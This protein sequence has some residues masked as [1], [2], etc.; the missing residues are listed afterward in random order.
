MYY[1]R[2][3]NSYNHRVVVIGRELWKSSVPTNP[4]SRC[5]LVPSLALC[6]FI[7]LSPVCPCLS[8]TVEPRTGS[9]KPGMTYP[10]LS[11][12]EVLPFNAAWDTIPFF[13]GKTPFWFKFYSLSTRTPQSFYLIFSLK[14]SMSWPV[15]TWT[16]QLWSMV[17]GLQMWVWLYYTEKPELAPILLFPALMVLL[18]QWWYSSMLAVGN[19]GFI[20]KFCRLL[21][22]CQYPSSPG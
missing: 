21:V 13:A 12:V 20:V 7:R 22:C 9:T 8:C 19:E 3:R 14:T 15:A 1:R 10:G 5:A 16:S 18:W 11:R 17:L 2:S 6:P 4:C